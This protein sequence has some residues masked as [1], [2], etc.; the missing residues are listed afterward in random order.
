MKGVKIVNRITFKKKGRLSFCYSILW[1]ILF[2]MIGCASLS[3]KEISE[4]YNKKKHHLSDGTFKNL[5]PS[6]T[7]KSFSD[8]IKWWWN[9]V[10]PKAVFFVST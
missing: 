3:S 2:N 7:K 1:V 9:G 10:T 5:Y 6:S 8:L 4:S